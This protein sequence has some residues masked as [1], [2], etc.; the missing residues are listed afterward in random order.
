MAH[1][2][3]KE[4]PPC[5]GA[6]SRCSGASSSRTSPSLSAPL[7]TDSLEARCE[8]RVGVLTLLLGAKTWRG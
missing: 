3:Q 4:V 7:L 6:A 2:K 8:R 5:C 1:R